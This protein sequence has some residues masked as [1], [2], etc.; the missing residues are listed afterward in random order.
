MRPW[1]S[2]NMI[3]SLTPMGKKHDKNLKTL[4]DF[5]KKVSKNYVII[6]RTLKKK[7]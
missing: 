1:L 7:L 2:P 5:T 4:H 6:L 3:F